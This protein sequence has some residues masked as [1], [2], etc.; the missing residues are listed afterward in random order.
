[1]RVID[2]RIIII[3]II[4]ITRAVGLGSGDI[5]LDGNELLPIGGTTSNFRPMFIVA[6]RLDG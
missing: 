4:I 3:I 6:K 1:V 2:F 5:V